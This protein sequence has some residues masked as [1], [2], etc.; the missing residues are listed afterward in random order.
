MLSTIS[1]YSLLSKR[2]GQ[3]Y[4]PECVEGKFSEVRRK[5]NVLTHLPQLILC[6]L[7][8]GQPEVEAEKP[9]PI[10]GA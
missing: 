8:K 6:A 1:G 9:A 4:S 3:P 7:G 2:G 10:M 5:Q